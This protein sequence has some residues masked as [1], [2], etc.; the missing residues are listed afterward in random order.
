MQYK[1]FGRSGLIATAS[2]VAISTALWASQA[3]AQFTL[4][5]PR[6]VPILLSGP[7]G[8]LH[9]TNSGS[10]TLNNNN[11]IWTGSVAP[12]GTWTIN[13]DGSLK[14]LPGADTYNAI[15]LL[16][17]G[18]VN[19]SST[20]QVEGTQTGIEIR[21]SLGNVQNDGIIRGQ[22]GAAIYIDAGGVAENRGTIVGGVA[23]GNA[24]GTF[25]N[26]S[27][28]S[29][30][31][32]DYGYP[33]GITM[34][35]GGSA[36]NS[37]TIEF[38][39]VG[40]TFYSA[41]DINFINSGTYSAVGATSQ[42]SSVMMVNGAVVADNSGLIKGRDLG[43]FVSGGTADVTNSGTIQGTTLHAVALHTGTGVASFKQTAGKLEGGRHGLS[44]LTKGD[45]TVAVSGGS[46]TG[47]MTDATGVGVIFRDS[48][49]TTIT[50]SNAT[51]SGRAA[52]IQG[53]SGTF[54]LKLG[55]GSNIQGDIK[56]GSGDSKLEI[57]TGVIVNGKI[58]G[59]AGV[60]TLRL[61]G[62]GSSTLSSD[63]LN[64]AALEVDSSGGVWKLTGSGTFADGIKIVAGELSVNG[65]FNA[66]TTV[67]AGALL[68]GNGTLGTTIVT[69][70]ATVAPGNSI[71][72]L[73][74]AG[75]LTLG[76]GSVYAV[77][78]GGGGAADLL[79]ITGK[80]ILQG[81]TVSVTALDPE[82]SYRNGQSYTIL[83]AAGGV[84]G[85]FD[86][87][88]LSKSAFL[89][90]DL[91]HTAN[92]V[93]LVI[94][95]KTPP[96]VVVPPIVKPKPEAPPLF[97]TVTQTQ[98]QY[99]TAG[100]LDRLEQKGA[101]LALYNRLLVLDAG[102]ARSAFDLL[103]G[104][105]HASIKGML[106]ED[107]HAMRDAVLAR[108]RATSRDAGS[109]ALPIMSFGPGG[110]D[111][112]IEDPDKLALWA[113]AFGSWGRWDGGANAA[114]FDRSTGGLLM[115]GDAAIGD[116]WRAGLVAGFS[117]T[118]FDLDARASSGNSDNYHL[119][120][121]GGGQWG[122]FGLRAGGAYTWH[123][124]ETAR[125]VDFSGFSDALAADYDAATAQVF[126]EAG[127]RFD[128]D[129]LHFEPFV[130]LA[131]VSVRNDGF[132]EKGNA[133]A[134]TA[135]SAASDV[136]FTT[137]GLRAETDFTL[138][139]VKASARGMIGW[140][141][142]FGDIVPQSGL[143]FANG[144]AFTVTG[145]PIAEDAAVID[146]G[147]DFAVSPVA[148]LGVSYSGQFAGKARDNGF[149]SQ[150]KISF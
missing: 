81:G 107:S 89:Q 19:V 62:A 11:A 40:Q 148:T 12:F 38:T 136:T 50:V 8:T 126:G 145:T 39:N 114:R 75:D 49:K 117:H 132:T 149:R 64:I 115:G 16:G 108:L 45:T 134:L 118:S 78:I 53:G 4:S 123:K 17:G 29:G 65:N 127:Y 120:V 104:E 135:S 143:A 28:I 110:T 3:A 1:A 122:A 98:N 61:T 10:I 124:L 111:I 34:S 146:A 7:T 22:K 54:D 59:E 74:V 142:A 119:G 87:T 72:T 79:S 125:T 113:D 44:V 150:L 97:T 2:V 102:S 41:G 9:V 96:V 31:G 84:V 99:A 23:F 52:A 71:G 58:D 147:V 106:L 93:A 66:A 35:K 76:S 100:A 82:A 116:H 51:I 30:N 141:H 90:A 69:S 37:G 46:I 32:N 18:T 13:V 27:S 42:T 83:T 67:G 47:G 94:A 6:T 33:Y 92:A 36:N 140:R 63:I 133:A 80:A 109:T 91:N 131:Y 129:A 70:G 130:G 73:H 57:A 60:N 137:I 112:A 139:D 121:F 15:Q 128:T 86:P 144:G 101:S 25:I 48:G 68:E 85:T 138:G 5:V 43:M 21:S 26:K 88:V 20:G 56:L 14:V 105:M 55:Q 95:T 24:P 77:E 103:S